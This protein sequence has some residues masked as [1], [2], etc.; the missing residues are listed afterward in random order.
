MVQGFGGV[1]RGLS[2]A[3]TRQGRI[4]WENGGECSGCHVGSWKVIIAQSVAEVV[5]SSMSPP[6]NRYVHTVLRLTHSEVQ[7]CSEEHETRPDGA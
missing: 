7:V 2:E 5:Y 1:W 3:R 4:Q 6:I